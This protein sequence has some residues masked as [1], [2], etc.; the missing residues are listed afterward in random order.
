MSDDSKVLSIKPAAGS[1]IVWNNGST[2][3]SIIPYKEGM[4]WVKTES[5]TCGITVDSVK[6][7]LKACDC[8]ILI[9][10]SF[11]PNEDGKNDYFFPVLTCEYSYYSLTIEDRWD[12]TVSTNNVNAKWDGRYKGN[13]CPDDIYI[14]RIETIEKKYTGRRKRLVRDK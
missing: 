13:L 7:K 8:E 4:Y 12:N 2:S 6:V 9:P 10:N 14:Y 11:T 3:N 1:K 5:K